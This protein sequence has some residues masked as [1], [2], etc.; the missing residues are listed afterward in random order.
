MKI[1]VKRPEILRISYRQEKGD[2]GYGS[3]LW[4]DFDFDQEEFMLN[5]QSDCGCAG[6]GW[7][8]TKSESFLQLMSR[9]EKDY[10]MEKLFQDNYVDVTRTMECVCDAL[11]MDD[12]KEP[13]S[14]NPGITLPP[15]FE[16][17]I[18]TYLDNDL[19][20]L[21]KK[22]KTCDNISQARNVLD[23][24]GRLDC[25]GEC[26]VADYSGNQK[27]IG[28]IFEMYIQP[29]IRDILETAQGD[30][31]YTVKRPRMKAYQRPNQDIRKAAK[32]AG[33]RLCD[34]AVCLGMGDTAFSRKMRYELSP[35]DK[36]R[37]F[38]VLNLINGGSSDE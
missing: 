19:K 22:L 15:W 8:V 4:A 16:A 25:A 23:E 21:E 37:A 18:M 36:R 20:N 13:D 33:L 10:L 6:Y 24:W 5:I 7:P 28:Q 38:D 17:E 35:E 26:A 29:K 30:D 3:C 12:K 27:K 34:L 31:S 9:I 1:E 32:K 11:H 14:E 2:K